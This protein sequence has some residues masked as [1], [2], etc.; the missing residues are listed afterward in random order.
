M[1]TFI[2]VIIIVLNGADVEIEKIYDLAY[3]ECTEEAA[4]F[5][6]NKLDLGVFTKV[7]TVCVDAG[8]HR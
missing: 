4:K 7:R 6:G 1:N 3:T 5:N 2:L 8:I